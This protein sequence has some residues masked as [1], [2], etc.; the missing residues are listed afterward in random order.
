MRT[1][2]VLSAIIAMLAVMV[3]VAVTAQERPP[4]KNE[5]LTG[6][7]N[8]ADEQGVFQL[9]VLQDGKAE[10]QILVSGNAEELAQHAKNHTVRVTGSMSD[11]GGTNVFKVS[12]IEHVD[13]TC[14]APTE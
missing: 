10:K 6:C 4:A 13:A 12:R 5:T 14:S 3:S 7:L 9:T 11:E 1:N 8:P 2:L